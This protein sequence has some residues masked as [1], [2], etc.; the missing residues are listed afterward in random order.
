MRQILHQRPQTVSRDKKDLCFL[1]ASVSL[2]YVKRLL[3]ALN[4]AVGLPSLLK[5][6]IILSTFKL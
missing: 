4:E 6:R 5:V 3:I 1:D 2:S